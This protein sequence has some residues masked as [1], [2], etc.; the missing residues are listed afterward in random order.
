MN[1]DSYIYEAIFEEKPKFKVLYELFWEQ[2]KEDGFVI[3]DESGHETDAVFKAVALQNI[4]GEFNY[5]MY[6]AVNETGLEDVIEYLQNIGVGE[7]DIIEYCESEPEIEIDPAEYE[8]TVKNPLDYVTEH[9]ANKL[10]EDYS[11]DDVFDYI[12]TATYDFEQDFTYDFEDTDEFLAFVD[13]NTERLDSY[14]EEYPSVMNWI[15][16]GMIC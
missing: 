6:D 11:A 16:N 7:S 12:F 4:V 8:A 13:S 9:A 10:L 2:F 1:I 3:T 15:E 14:K 5:R